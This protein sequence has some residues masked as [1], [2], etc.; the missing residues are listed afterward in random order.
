MGIDRTTVA[1]L[2]ALALA[3][4]APFIAGW[5]GKS[6]DPYRDIVGV[7]TV[8]YGETNVSMRHYS[9]AECTEMLNDS[10]A[11]YRDEVLRCTPVLQGH[12]IQLAAATSL[13][14]NIGTGAYCRSTVARRFNS[15]DFKGACEGFKAWNR[16]GGRVIPGLV[17]RRNA[18][19]GLCVTYLQ[20]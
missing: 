18:E 15:G 4:A 10:V 2:S 12:P 11:E 6:N 9:N 1:A 13:A 19:Y 16:A 17:N 7:Q 20:P 14:Y 3:I 5:E 8:C